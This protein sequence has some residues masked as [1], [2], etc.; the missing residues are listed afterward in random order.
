MNYKQLESMFALCYSE[1]YQKKIHNV[2]ELLKNK[3]SGVY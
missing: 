2:D 3:D 1:T